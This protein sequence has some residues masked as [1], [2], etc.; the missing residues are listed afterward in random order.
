[1]REFDLNIERVLENWTAA[2][3]LRE[4]IANALDEHALTGSAEPTIYKDGNGAWHIRAAPRNCPSSHDPN[5]PARTI[6]YGP[7]RSPDAT[8]HGGSSAVPAKGGRYIPSAASPGLPS[9]VLARRM[10]IFLTPDRD[11]PYGSK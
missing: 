5:A 9:M 7:Q 4:I 3:A 2:H 11:R 1:M 8:C 10:L 6:T